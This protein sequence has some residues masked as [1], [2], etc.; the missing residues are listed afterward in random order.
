VAPFLLRAVAPLRETS[1]PALFSLIVIVALCFAAP[2]FAQSAASVAA[3]AAA[4]AAA[5][6]PERAGDV[7]MLYAEAERYARK[8]YEAFEREGLGY[9]Q[10]L[11]E[12]VEREQR[13]LA[14]R[15]AAEVAARESRV[16]LNAREI[17]YLGQL[18][19]IADDG[20]R[21][22]AAMFRFLAE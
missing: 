5:T 1:P 12:E 15:Y 9:D 6:T 7:A 10:K 4:A 18:Y 22:V 14:A 3:P 13:A 11:V 2:S 17:F 19:N 21:A 8:K 20:E 16:A